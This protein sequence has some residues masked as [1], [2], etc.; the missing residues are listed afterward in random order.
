MATKNTKLLQL[1]HPCESLPRAY[2]R[3]EAFICR[4]GFL[5]FCQATRRLVE[6]LKRFGLF[7]SFAPLC[8]SSFQ[9]ARLEVLAG[10]KA[11]LIPAQPNGLGNLE[12]KTMRAE[13]PFH[14]TMRRAFSPHDF[15]FPIPSPLGWYAFSHEGHERR[16]FLRRSRCLIKPKVARVCEGYLGCGFEKRTTSKRLPQIHFQT[17]ATS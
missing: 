2:R 15:V 4:T 6:W 7:V 1:L 10:P 9:R 14:Q 16:V 12:A 13:G 5:R 8:G 11:R 17:E 3:L